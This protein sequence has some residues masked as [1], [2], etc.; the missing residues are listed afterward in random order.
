[1][2]ST[3]PVFQTG[4]ARK[5]RRD[6]HFGRSKRTRDRAGKQEALIESALR[7]FATKG[8]EATTTREIAASAGCAEGLIHRYFKGKAGLLPALVERQFSKEVVDLGRELQPARNLEAEFI[9]LVDWEV[10]R[11]WETRDFFKVFIP[12]ALVDSSL[13]EVKNRV[14]SIRAKT[15]LERLRRYKFCTNLPPHELEALAQAVGMLGLVFGF[16]RPLVLGQDRLPA[17][18]MAGI[19]AKMLIRGVTSSGGNYIS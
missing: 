8:Y 14:I 1:M 12:R 10:E 18:Q 11:F 16:M 13:A 5:P 9:Q 6:R 3:S 4:M 19:V 15:I 17:R 2:N 7:L